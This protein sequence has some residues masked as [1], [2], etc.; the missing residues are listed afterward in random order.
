M[1]FSHLEQRRNLL[2]QIADSLLELR[3]HQLYAAAGLIFALLQKVKPDP[4]P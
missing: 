4:A 3:A 1:L 2:L